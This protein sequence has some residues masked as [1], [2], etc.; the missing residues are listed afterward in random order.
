M[1][2][3]PVG[4]RSLNETIDRNGLTRTSRWLT[5]RDSSDDDDDTG[6]DVDDTGDDV[7]ELNSCFS[8]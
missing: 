2:R 4:T 1:D 5:A 3:T 7:D 6:D 8:N